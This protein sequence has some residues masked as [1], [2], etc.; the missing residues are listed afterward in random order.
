MDWSFEL[1]SYRARNG[2]KQESLADLLQISQAYVSRLESG[3]AE[4]KDGLELKIRSLISKP[5]QM[6]VLDFVLNAVRVSPH[7]AA[8]LRFNGRELLNVASSKALRDHPQFE[9]VEEGRPVDLSM[10]VERRR[11]AGDVVRLGAFKGE[12]SRIEVLWSTV[13]DGEDLYWDSVL[14]PIR[15]GQGDWYLYNALSP[16]TRDEFDRRAAER[17]DKLRVHRSGHTDFAFNNASF[18][19]A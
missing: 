2:L 5:A 7:I 16:V 11:I 6:D 15:S 4:P 18:T 9:K 12:I 1:R 10:I 3:K 19:A 14:T 17:G 13:L 8:I